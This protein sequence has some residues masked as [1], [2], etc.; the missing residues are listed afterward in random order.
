MSDERRVLGITTAAATAAA[1]VVRL[2]GDGHPAHWRSVLRRRRSRR[3]VT[4]RR[5][6]R[7]TW[8][9][10]RAFIIVRNSSW[11][12][13][14][15][16]SEGGVAGACAATHPNFGPPNIQRESSGFGQILSAGNGRIIQFGL[17]FYF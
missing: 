11:C 14:S 2:I 16:R 6:R 7:I 13:A 3:W 17:K 9:G 5:A 4:S 12:T 1:P 8:Q 10:V 15:L